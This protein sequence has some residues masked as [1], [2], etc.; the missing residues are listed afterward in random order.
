MTTQSNMSM[1]E[2]ET[3]TP[4]VDPELNHAK[5]RRGGRLALYTRRFLRNKLAVVG[6]FILVA[7]VLFSVVGQLL[8]KYG[9]QDTDFM[10]L[11]TA[12]DDK[13]WLGTNSAGN[14]LFIQLAISIRQ[15]LLIGLI[16]SS[17]YTVL[18]SI[19]GAMVAFVRGI[20]EEIGLGFL[21]FLLVLPSFLI[22][23]MLTNSNLIPR[24]KV[25]SWIILMIFMIITGWFGGARVVYSLTTS[26]RER[27]YVTAAT[28]MGVGA[29][30]NVVRHVVPNIGSL[31]V[32]NWAYGVISVVMGET[33]LSYLGF[34][35]RYPDVS[36]GLLMNQGTGSYN[37]QPWLLIYPSIALTLLTVSAAFISDG[38]RDALD[39]NSAAGGH[40]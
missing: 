19:Y 34:G 32:I 26:L 27:D 38:L 40:A 36:L 1:V 18:S 10:A 15:S 8:A 6:L 25:P 35:I 39:P 33:A 29:F 31:L 30:K 7:L 9:P 13:H 2:A 14:D 21:N 28:F 11:G 17:A 12:P 22:L 3:E 5:R 23:A 20:W 16:V 37:T 24:D 4:V